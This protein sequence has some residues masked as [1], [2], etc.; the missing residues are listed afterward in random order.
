MERK[1]FFKYPYLLILL[2][3]IGYYFATIFIMKER[4]KHQILTC[5]IAAVW[6]INGLVCKVLNLVP[7]H[8]K[9]VA[10]ILGNDHARGLTLLIGLLEMVMAAWIL[11]GIE[12]RLNALTQILVVAIMNALEFFLV[13]DLLLWGKANACFAFL[14]INLIYYNEFLLK[15]K[16]ALPA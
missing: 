5:I 1:A 7:R 15:K 9:I 8:Q 12:T 2:I 6:L 3:V 13:P 16:L 4:R 10:N 14:F 11:S